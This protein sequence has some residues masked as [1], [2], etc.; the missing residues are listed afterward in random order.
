M[1]APRGYDATGIQ[2]FG[3]LQLSSD[4]G[5]VGL[6]HA[7]AGLNFD[8]L[9]DRTKVYTR[10]GS[11]RVGSAN[12]LSGD[13]CHGLMPAR[14][15]STDYM[16]AV[17]SSG[18][19]WYLDRV[20]TSGTVVAVGNW[21]GGAGGAFPVMVPFG[22]PTSTLAF[23]AIGDTTMRKYD[24]TTL[25]TSTGKPKFIA[26]TPWSNR[27]VQ[28]HFAAAADTPSGAN[29]STSTVFFSDAGAPETYGANN[30]VHLRP[31]DGEQITG[32]VTWR[33][34]TFVFKE[35]VAF[36]FF[37]ESVDSTGNPVFNYRRL[38]L[39]SA[40]N[41]TLDFSMMS[42]GRRGVFFIANDGIYLTDGNQPEKVS[43][44]LD[45]LFEAASSSYNLYGLSVTEERIAFIHD[46]GS[47]ISH[48][49]LDERHGQWSVWQFQQGATSMFAPLT[50]WPS[51]FPFGHVVFFALGDTLYRTSPTATDDQG[52]AIV[53]SYQTGF[54]D[55]GYPGQ[56]V[57]RQQ[58]VWGT[59]S[60]TASMAV[61]Y[62]SPDSGTA[63]TLG[64][65]PAVDEG[66]DRIARRGTYF[67][68][69]VA[70]SS[71]YW[72]V[73]AISLQVRDGRLTGMRAT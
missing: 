15:S 1:S 45:A 40:V 28:G 71:G 63:L 55:L 65:S 12:A 54:S 19:T 57:V 51:P 53:S 11:V 32:V 38:T 30:Y 37:G 67:S 70:A 35:T 26:V 25:S 14:F 69:K 4:S 36:V 73:N 33:D 56:K 3:G 24:G 72:A 9:P 6:T 41:K 34:L 23:V 8:L 18:S 13:H 50:S 2:Q 48:Y 21:A 49:V 16:L 59:G 31:G 27:L 64:V 46:T 66:L 43:G 44:P 47:T 42:A 5:D 61:D 10:A 17:L 29:G 62:G 68:T 52:V 7:I 60:L 39:P 58:Q 22:T 20:T